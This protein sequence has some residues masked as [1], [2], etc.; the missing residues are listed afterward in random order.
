MRR[1]VL[2]GAV[3]LQLH[4]FTGE[5]RDVD[6]TIATDKVNG[7]RIDRA[8]RAL[9]AEPFLAGERGTAYRTEYGQLEVMR[10]TA[11]VGDYDAWMRNASNLE[12][13]PGLSVAVGAA[14]DLLLSKEQAARQKDTDALPWIRAELLAK[15][16]L[17]SEDVRGPVA[18]LH[19][20]QPDPRLQDLLGPRPLSRRERG[21]WDHAAELVLDY[22]KRWSIPE[23]GHLLGPQPSAGTPQAADRASLNGQLKR[24]KRLLQGR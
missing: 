3:A 1:F 4:G 12:L 9:R 21:L 19:Y 2:V 13:A 22:R 17:R 5:T 20:E 10:F 8:L 23:D 7:Q 15:G 6:I 24:L 14:S 11:G 18:D 16:T